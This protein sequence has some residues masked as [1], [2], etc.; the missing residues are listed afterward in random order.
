MP[1]SEIKEDVF[2]RQFATCVRAIR[3]GANE[4]KLNF[5]PA[6]EPD[7]PT[8]TMRNVTYVVQDTGIWL[9]GFD[10][11]V[12]ADPHDEDA[13]FKVGGTRGSALMAYVLAP[14]RRAFEQHSQIRTFIIVMDKGYFMPRPKHYTQ[15]VRTQTLVDAMER[16]GITPLEVPESGELPHLI[17]PDKILPPWMAV[18]A[19]RTL[20]RH[21]TCELLDWIIATYVP[22]PGCRLIVDC[23]DTVASSPPSLDKWMVSDRIICSDYAREKIEEARALLRNVPNWRS[24]ARKLLDELGQAGYIKSVPLCIETALDGTRRLPYLLPNAANSFGEADIGIPGWLTLMQTDRQHQTLMGKRR[25]AEK[26]E[27]E[28]EEFYTGA[29]VDAHNEAVE[30]QEEEQM[31]NK[32]LTQQREWARKFMAE[33][34]SSKNSVFAEISAAPEESDSVLVR[35][36]SSLLPRITE[37]NPCREPNRALVLT[38]DTDFLS[39]LPMWWE[40]LAADCA[41]ADKPKQYAID[42]APLLCVG[43]CQVLRTG[44]LSGLTDYYDKPPATKRKKEDIA[45]APPPPPMQ[46][47]ITCHEVW[48]VAKMSLGLRVL[49]DAYDSEEG[50][51]DAST[52]GPEYH[53]ARAASFA[54]FCASCGNDYLAGL[55]Y[56][57]RRDMLS[58][59]FACGGGKLVQYSPTE[60]IGVI[61]PLRYATFI[62]YCYWWSLRGK[63]GTI[64][65][66]PRPANQ[67]TYAE[68]A[69]VVRVKYQANNK[70]HMPDVPT[71]K[72]MYQR[73]QW[74]LVYAM[75]AHVNIAEV[76]DHELW[77]WPE[78]TSDLMV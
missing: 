48:D 33:I 3:K 58:A 32:S 22:P 76:L 14:V 31:F 37:Q 54:M 55:Y 49:Y 69:A 2:R 27:Y 5:I 56:V 18:R 75:R 67:M 61:T 44:W 29:Q 34:E 66:P 11:V 23:L 53:L 72:L 40:Q 38:T 41:W 45:P 28:E 15:V 68:M 77:G 51:D 57:N 42:N 63:R 6:P 47:P 46:F 64:N 43:P 73:T 74:W 4:S 62:K 1:K 20:Y 26:M 70:M 16:R 17:Q 10:N 39:L 25:A 19:N 59:F 35:F 36:A 7:D 50:D 9:H 24:Q 8:Q 21:A 71:L 52:I 12:R 78:G 60:K 13:G 65:K 30:M